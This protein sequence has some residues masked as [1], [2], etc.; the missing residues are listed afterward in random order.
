MQQVNG[1]SPLETRA[2]FSLASIYSL[3]MLGLFMIL[4][5]FALYA[6]GL[7]GV[8][9]ALVGVA[10]GIYGLTQAIFQIPF[11]MLSDR[12]GRKPV[13]AAG[14]LI[15]AA[16]SVFAAMAD[17]IWGVI[18]G[19]A[20]QGSGAIAAAIM[21]LTADLTR[22]ENRL[23]AMAII[24]MSIGLAFAV[25]M[26]AGPILNEWLQ[27]NGIFWLTSVLAVLGIAVLY[28]VVPTPT[29]QSFHR[30][31]EPVPAQFKS[32]FLNP[33]LMRTNVGVFMLHMAL[34]AMFVVTP[35]ALRDIAQ[36]PSSDHWWVYLP[37]MLLA[38][39]IMVP[40]VIVAENKRRMKQVMTSAVIIAAISQYLL[41][42]NLDS[43]V[44]IGLCLFLF[45]IG[46]NSL[47]AT[48]PSLVVKIAPPH[49]KGTAMG[50]FTSFQFIGA[51]SGGMVGGLLHM[52]F[53]ISSVFLMTGTLLIFWTLLISSMRNPRYL[54]S[55]LVHVGAIDDKEAQHLVTEMTR[56]TGVA[57][58]IV[59][60]E[61]GIA[62]L[63]VDLKALDREALLKFHR[64]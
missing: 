35:I 20:L 37:V 36:L 42:I 58:A 64:D 43:A 62:Y 29:K 6:E 52:H 61:D 40:L 26:V 22:E 48:L 45:F 12:I 34:T 1:M 27:V 63:K 53:G 31:T 17:D 13:I 28:L 59:I 41:I 8:T 25:S 23:R 24:G 30:D 54:S 3:R 47:E 51:F 18:I 14:L 4:P 39:I 33:E 9:P 2:T 57:E 10:I 44:T 38:M 60:A 55:F 56:V 7:E 50:V 21:A 19:R 11:G 32:V 46:F 16:G 15:F 49:Y 5:V